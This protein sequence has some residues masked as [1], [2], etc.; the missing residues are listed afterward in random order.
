MEL[1]NRTPVPALLRIAEI[2]EGRPR[3]GVL[4]AKATFRFDERGSV[5]RVD[6][7]PVPIFTSDEKTPLG[8]LPRD[9][10]PQGGPAFEVMLLGCAHAPRGK[11]VPQMTV[12]L[13]VGRVSRQLAVFGD[14]TWIN[15]DK[16]GPRR[17][18]S[19]PEP[20]TTMPLTWERAFGGTARVLVDEDSPV[21]VSDPRNA[22][23]RGFDPEPMATGLTA[24]IGAPKGFPQ[25]ARE[26]VLPNVE[27][28]ERL[29][30]RW[31]DAPD[32]ICW[33][34]LPLDSMIHALR[35]DEAM[36]DFDDE[37]P[38][39]P[40]ADVHFRAHPEWVIDM[41]GEGTEV[42]L[43]G[44]TPE[45]RVS[46]ALPRQRVLVDWCVSGGEGS[47]EL[48]PVALVVLAEERRFTIVYRHL[49]DYVFEPRGERSLRLRLEEGWFANDAGGGG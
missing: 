19:P 35:V 1:V 22:A 27:H 46:F 37:N 40:P 26:R 49:F 34:T 5:E 43:E 42:T 45:G 4:S 16:K 48:R 24:Q 9:D 23:G 47:E 8:L 6:D 11:P 29:V 2:I 14:R 21:L 17:F 32:P 12:R 41:P 13:S 30:K 7:E 3:I 25:W 18:V 33:A 38:T 36:A 39:Y 15:P 31:D 28:P 44:L 10:L 20:F